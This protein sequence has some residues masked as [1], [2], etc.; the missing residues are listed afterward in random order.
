M[1]T[2]TFPNDVVY[3][4]YE[5][6]TT[7]TSA[8]FWNM[9]DPAAKSEFLDDVGLRAKLATLVG[10]H[11]ISILPSFLITDSVDYRTRSGQVARKGN[12]LLCKNRVALQ[13]RLG[14]VCLRLSAC[15]AG[16]LSQI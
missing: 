5:I 12:L 8:Q 15:S 1:G 14:F 11:Q 3:V 9:E 10:R 4:N 6:C 16:P 2:L 13:H 7:E